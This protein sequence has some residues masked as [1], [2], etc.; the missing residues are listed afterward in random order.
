VG[1]F[2]LIAKPAGFDMADKLI[3]PPVF[4]VHFS[5][6]AQPDTHQIN[7]LATASQKDEAS[8]REQLNAFGDALKNKIQQQAFTWKGIGQLAA[9]DTGA[10]EFYPEEIEVTGLGAIKANRVIRENVGH[11]VLMGDQ[12]MHS[13]DAAELLQEN[14]ERE[15][16]GARRKRRVLIGAG[17]AIVLAVLFI[18][19]YFYSTGFNPAASGYQMKVHPAAPAPTYH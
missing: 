12:E 9:S 11:T 14:E 17:I 8:A 4:T 6:V 2:H 15:Q 5:T 7:Y 18:V 10:V 16:L 1:Q 13:D 3:H 19:Y